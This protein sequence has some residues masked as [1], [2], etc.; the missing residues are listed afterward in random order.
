M[1]N[2]VEQNNGQMSLLAFGNLELSED[3]QRVLKETPIKSNKGVDCGMSYTIAGRK[4]L[5]AEFGLKGK[6]NSEALDEAILKRTDEALTAMKSRIAGLNG[7]W[8]FKKLAT[9]A[10]SNGEMQATIVLRKVTR[11]KGV[12][13]E[14]IAQAYGIP[15]EKVEQFIKEQQARVDAN[16]VEVDTVEKEERNAIDEAPAELPP[17]IGERT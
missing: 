5:A 7:D 14:K 16:T 6:D 10:L 8:T 17:I 2:K 12:S 3:A 4:D 13:L 15:I 11:K 1:A 9:R